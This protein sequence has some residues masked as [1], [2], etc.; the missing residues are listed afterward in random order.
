M[1][2]TDLRTKLGLSDDIESIL[3]MN[4]GLINTCLALTG[5]DDRLNLNIQR[6]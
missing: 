2:K 1:K 3:Q 4:I 6:N 5:K